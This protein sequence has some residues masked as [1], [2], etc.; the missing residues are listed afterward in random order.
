MIQAVVF[1]F[2]QTLVDSADGFRAAEKGAQEKAYA[3]LGL[4]DRETFLARYREIRGAFHARS[5]FSRKLILEELFVRYGRVPDPALLEEWETQYWRRI[6]AMTR[7]FPETLT[8]LETLR[9]RGYRL[10]LVTNAQGQQKAGM[11]RIGNYPEL[12]RFFEVIIVAGEAGIPAKPDP[13]PFLLCLEKL[14]VAAADSVYVGDDWRIDVCGS[15]AVGMHPIW[16][17]HKS[18]RR[19]WPAVETDVPVID[20]L[21]G[22]GDIGALLS[23]GERVNR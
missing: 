20:S 10:A 16:L 15:G 8:V 14:G 9:G 7:V 23:K 4:T 3:A 5:Q 12:E 11:H 21:E 6:R 19:N 22:L 13:A 18:V 2:G 1:D 17:R